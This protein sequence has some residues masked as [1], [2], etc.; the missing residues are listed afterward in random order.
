[1]S[2][3]L[4]WIAAALL[5]VALACA[6]S[7]AEQAVPNAAPAPVAAAAT[8]ASVR[9][10]PRSLRV[11]GTLVAVDDAD[12]AAESAGA[13]SQIAADRGD[14]VAR[15]APL[16][17]LDSAIASLQ[18]REASASVAAAEVQLRQ[19]D[20]DCTRAQA[21]TEA[22]GLSTAER[23]RL[24]SQ[25]EQGAR[26]LEAARARKSL[27]DTNLGRATV[28]APFAGVVAERMVS[29]G[30]Y[31]GP[32]RTVVKL[33]ALDPLRLELSVPERAAS[34]VQIGARVRFEVNDRPGQTFEATVTRLSPALRERTRDLVVEASVP[35]PDGA[36]RPNSFVVANLDLPVASAVAVP[37]SAIVRRGDTARLYVNVA[38]VAE[39]R[40]VELGEQDGD[41]VEVRDGVAEGEAVLA[42]VPAGM[43]DGVTLAGS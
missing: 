33:V 8:A 36:L 39:E 4:P 29:L 15:G 14:L 40:V 30:E 17:V 1:M 32:G 28:R 9:D 42:P 10:V 2:R 5:P 31:V 11:T 34:L 37:M 35:N 19:A 41:W 21:L 22:G 6:G 18:A 20:A 12:V 27:A 24:L 25:C 26:Q 38:G 16:L 13:V 3:R 7:G 43:G 23:D